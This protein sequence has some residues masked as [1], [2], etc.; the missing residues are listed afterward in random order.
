MASSDG[1]RKKGLSPKFYLCLDTASFQQ[2]LELYAV[3]KLVQL[4]AIG[5]WYP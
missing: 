4:Q 3:K 1:K 2:R 5:Y